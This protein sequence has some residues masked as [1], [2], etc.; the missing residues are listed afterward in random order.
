MATKKKYLI[1][2]AAANSAAFPESRV[3]YNAAIEGPFAD[4]TWPYTMRQ[5]SVGNSSFA[6]FTRGYAIIS[7]GEFLCSKLQIIFTQKNSGDKMKLGIYDSNYQLV[8]S[9]A[10]FT[11]GSVTG[12][13]GDIPLTAPYLVG[14]KKM[15]YLAF[16]IN[17]SAPGNTKWPVITDADTLT[18]EP[19]S[20]VSDQSN[21]LPNTIGIG[22]IINGYRVW[23]GWSA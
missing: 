11:V 10:L 9:T 5:N 22:S 13:I 12:H 1:E 14:A 20:Q 8:A 15:Y 3:E 2:S 19:L 21:M 18:T 4:A 6:T 23:M 17:S 16:G 7:K